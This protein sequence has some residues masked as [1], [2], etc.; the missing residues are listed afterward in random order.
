MKA[1][2]SLVMMLTMVCAASAT[3]TVTLVPIAEGEPGSPTNPLQPSEQVLVYVTSDGGL[4]GLDAVL[5]VV[6]GP[7]IIIDA[8]CPG[9]PWDPIMCTGPI[10]WPEPATCAEIGVGSFGVM[11]PGI[12]AWFLIH[13][14]GPNDVNLHLSAGT[15]LGG[16]MDANFEVPTIAGQMTIYQVSEPPKNCQMHD[17]CPA[18]VM[19]DCTCDG[20]INLADLYAFKSCF[21]DSAPWTGPCC[22]CDYNNDQH[23]SLGDL[24]VLK[25]GFGSGPYVPSTGNQNCP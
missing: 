1:L 3:T 2:L 23:I 5:C 11:P 25:A 21:G 17:V 15:A 13:C 8:I 10:F 7:A 24:F 6:S 12:I 18:Q 4:L 22:C 20:R 14:D 9:G 19:G 16:S